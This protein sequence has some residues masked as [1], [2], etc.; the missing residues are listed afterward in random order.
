MEL[1]TLVQQ[2]QPYATVITAVFSVA[3]LGLVINIFRLAR[4]AAQERVK[5]FEDRLAAA[6]EDQERTEKWHK[7]EQERLE[8]ELNARKQQLDALLSRAGVSLETITSDQTLRSIAADVRT[9]IASL[10][11]EMRDRLAELSATAP[12]FPSTN[13]DLRLTLAKGEFATGRWDAAAEDLDS[14]AR[15]DLTEN[16]RAHFARAVAHA[17]ARE[18]DASNLMALRAYNDAIALAPSDLDPNTRARL[19]GYRGAILKRLRRLDEAE[20]DLLIASRHA[21]GK[22]EISDIAYNLAGVYAMRSNREKTLAALRSLGQYPASLAAVRSH[23]RDYFAA[24]EDDEEFLELIGMS[25]N[26]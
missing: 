17:N 20:A 6:K 5:V 16:W 26:S 9:Q 1:N 25:K 7:R 24:Y 21:T 14:Y 3:T 23:L 18:G 11:S 22:Y 19:L 8:R 10:V 12:T 13:G 2:L 4:E 15:Q